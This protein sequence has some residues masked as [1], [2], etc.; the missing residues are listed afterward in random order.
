LRI[1]NIESSVG[2]W[3]PELKGAA[4][5]FLLIRGAI[6]TVGPYKDH[7]FTFARTL[8]TLTTFALFQFCY[9]SLKYNIRGHLSMK[10]LLADYVPYRITADA[11]RTIPGLHLG[12]MASSVT[13][14]GT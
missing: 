7:L 5:F 14:Q 4:P 2:E 8:R 12:F 1:H 3:M 10:I 9:F 6:N 11:I 13:L